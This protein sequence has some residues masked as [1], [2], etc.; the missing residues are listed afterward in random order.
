MDMDLVFFRSFFTNPRHA[1]L[2]SP[3]KITPAVFDETT[4][5]VVAD[6][7]HKQAGELLGLTKVKGGNIL[8]TVLLAAACMVFRPAEGR[9]SMWLTV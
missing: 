3:L 2:S 6:V 5:V 8:E 9:C 4:P 7:T 1:G